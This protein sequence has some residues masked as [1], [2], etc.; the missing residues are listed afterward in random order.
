[1]A[2]MASVVAWMASASKVCSAARAS[3]GLPPAPAPPGP[4]RRSR[5]GGADGVEAVECTSPIASIAVSRLF[6]QAAVSACR[7]STVSYL[8]LRLFEHGQIRQLVPLFIVQCL[9]GGLPLRSARRS[10]RSQ[11]RSRRSPRPAGPLLQA[12]SV[13]SSAARIASATVRFMVRF[14]HV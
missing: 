14:L 8:G 4:R 12:Q 9:D 7:S 11:R 13:R 3:R 10:P 2:R 1:M 5:A 6:T